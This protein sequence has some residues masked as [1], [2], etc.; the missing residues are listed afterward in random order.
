MTYSTK[1]KIVEEFLQGLE[2]GNST[3]PVPFKAKVSMSC[4][5]HPR[6]ATLSEHLDG[7]PFG[8]I[9]TEKEYVLTGIG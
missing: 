1:K 4:L 5:H 3:K 7:R 8:E 2:K 9:S 6:L